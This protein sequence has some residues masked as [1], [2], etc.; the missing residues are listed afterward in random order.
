MGKLAVFIVSYWYLFYF[1]IML[2]RKGFPKVI[3]KLEEEI[4]E[5]K[6]GKE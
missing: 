1:Y 2:R 5:K 6:I 3:K 4:R